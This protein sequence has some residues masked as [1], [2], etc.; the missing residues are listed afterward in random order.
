MNRVSLHTSLYEEVEVEEILFYP[1]IVPPSSLYQK[2]AEQK[3]KRQSW[4]V[5][6]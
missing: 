6:R 3:N 5:S 1:P 2:M 4:K